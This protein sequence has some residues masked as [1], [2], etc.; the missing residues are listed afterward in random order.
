MARVQGSDKPLSRDVVLLARAV[1]SCSG[2]VLILLSVTL[3]RP[4]CPQPA[5]MRETENERAAL[6]DPAAPHAMPPQPAAALQTL[7]CVSQ[8][9]PHFTQGDPFAWIAMH[10]RAVQQQP[11]DSLIW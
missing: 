8:G 2:S 6:W 5:G 3:E 11:Q 10:T 1:Y 7:L 4:C 9:K